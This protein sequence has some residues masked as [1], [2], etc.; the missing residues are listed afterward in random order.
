VDPFLA[1]GLRAPTGNGLALI[2]VVG[3]PGAVAVEVE[4]EPRP[5][6]A[7]LLI[8][9]DVAQAEV[10]VVDVVFVLHLR[11]RRW[12]P[13]LALAALDERRV[14]HLTAGQEEHRAE[15]ACRRER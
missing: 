2:R 7:V 5:E 4:A 1:V 9:H 10:D 12:A 15:G 3:A 14:V 8:E 13:A 6:P 11:A